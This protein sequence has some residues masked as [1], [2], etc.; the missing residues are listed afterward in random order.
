M[1]FAVGQGHGIKWKVLPE[2]IHMKYQS[3]STSQLKMMTKIK[4]LE[5]KVK[6]Q[7][8]MSEGQ[9]HSI[10]WKVLPEGI[11]SPIPTNQKYDQG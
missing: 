10:K 11:H 6:L 9:H 3:Q 4:V 1:C 7:G 2:V 8:Q 5:K